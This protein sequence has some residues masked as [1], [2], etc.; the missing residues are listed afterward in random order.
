MEEIDKPQIAE[1][2]I[3]Q[4]SEWIN[5]GQTRDYNLTYEQGV[6]DALSWLTGISPDEPKIEPLHEEEAP[7]ASD[8]E[9]SGI[10]VEP[11]DVIPF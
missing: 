3:N 8:G 10:H 9:G 6:V 1:R 2:L 11:N 4:A 7:Q 5:A